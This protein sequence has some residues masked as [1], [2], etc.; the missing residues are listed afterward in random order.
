MCDSYGS[1]K[2]PPIQAGGDCPPRA[3]GSCVEHG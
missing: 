3:E 2:G 1:A